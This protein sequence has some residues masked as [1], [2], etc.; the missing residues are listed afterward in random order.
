[1]AHL[2]LVGIGVMGGAFALNLAEKG[3]SVSLL[4]RSAEKMAE[5]V[6]DA[7]DQD[8]T[9]E[10]IACADADAFVQSLPTPRS[11]LVLVPSGGPLDSVIGM[12]KPA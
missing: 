1:M 10:L 4:D 3:H 7:K 2:G 11:I 12:L 6:Q 5:A 8:L 9:G